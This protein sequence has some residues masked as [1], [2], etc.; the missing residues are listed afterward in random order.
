MKSFIVLSKLA[1]AGTLVPV[2]RQVAA[3]AARA[4]ALGRPAAATPASPANFAKSRLRTKPP[5]DRKRRAYRDQGV[6]QVVRAT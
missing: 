1:S 4:G 5:Q 2:T 3:A 6:P